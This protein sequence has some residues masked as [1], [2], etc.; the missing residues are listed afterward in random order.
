MSWGNIALTD[1][2]FYTLMARHADV[3][4]LNTVEKYWRAA[5]EVIIREMYINRTCRVPLIGTFYAK[6]IGETFQV[7]KGR[8]GK[9]KIYKVEPRIRPL[10][11]PHDDFI[12]DINMMAVTKRGR[13]RVRRNTMTQ[14]DYLRQIRADALGVDGSLSEERMENSRKKFKE[15]LQQKK[16]KGKVDL[17]EDED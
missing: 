11:E 14:R 1:K 15:M 7:Q 16:V 2:E 6:E 5:V 13:K 10:F 3:T 9:E 8:D 12:N 4:N 17:E